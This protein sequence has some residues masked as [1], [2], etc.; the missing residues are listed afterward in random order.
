MVDVDGAFDISILV[1]HLVFI[2]DAADA[3][4]PF[5]SRR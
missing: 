1:D 2:W 3:V 4:G 5:L